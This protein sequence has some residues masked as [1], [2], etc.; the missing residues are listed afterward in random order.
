[1]SITEG[2]NVTFTCQFSRRDNNITIF[3]RVDDGQYDCVTAE[4]D[5]GAG[6]SG[7]FT[8][9]TQSVLL[10]RNATTGIH[11]VQCILQHNF[12]NEYSE[13]ASFKEEFNNPL[14]NIA[15]LNILPKGEFLYH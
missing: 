12:S 11:P 3:W 9:D 8:N 13:D 10:V 7:C 5:I 15:F 14:T 4:E 2:E 1:M 6:S